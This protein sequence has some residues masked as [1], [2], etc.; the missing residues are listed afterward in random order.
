MNTLFSL[1]ASFLL[2]ISITAISYASSDTGGN[3]NGGNNDSPHCAG[4]T[5]ITDWTYFKSTLTS[6]TAGSSVSNGDLGSYGG[7]KANILAH[8]G[9]FVN[10]TH[11]FI[12]NP[13]VKAGGI[14]DATITLSLR[15]F[16]T[17]LASK[18]GEHNDDSVDS[19]GNERSRHGSQEYNA[20]FRVSC[21]SSNGGPGP[22]NSNESAKLLLEGSNWI[23]INDVDT[24]TK[25]F[26]VVLMGLYDGRFDVQLVSTLNDFEIEWSK[27]KIEYCP[28]IPAP[29]PE[30]STI[31]LLG[32]GLLGAGL[33]RRRIRK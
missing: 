22:N 13:A 8:T 3:C 10:W 32:V 28:D 5:T 4:K 26:D 30:P 18:S 21:D 20:R 14:L 23:T 29:V 1:I 31:V 33:I 9:D 27:L 7:N 24:G 6:D 12:F 25:K 15:D 16:E 11:Q 19:E 2:T 17:D